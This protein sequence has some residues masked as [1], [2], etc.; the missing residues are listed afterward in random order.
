MITYHVTVLAVLEVT[1]LC[2]IAHISYASC[3]PQFTHGNSPVQ[4]APDPR[5][6][7]PT[8]LDLHVPLYSSLFR[9]DNEWDPVVPLLLDLARNVL[10]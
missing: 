9:S 7:S 6:P 4:L 8:H 10:A 3:M 5:L 2:G 1:L